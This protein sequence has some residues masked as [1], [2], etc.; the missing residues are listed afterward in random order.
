MTHLHSRFDDIDTYFA[1][2]PERD[3]VEQYS[4][5]CTEWLLLQPAVQEI[6]YDPRRPL[7]GQ[8]C[9]YQYFQLLEQHGVSTAAE[10]YLPT[11]SWFMRGTISAPLLLTA[12]LMGRGEYVVATAGDFPEDLYYIIHA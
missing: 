12:A 2:L 1:N 7:S 5:H 4:A 10:E 9:Y 11:R 8:D 6:G 3:I